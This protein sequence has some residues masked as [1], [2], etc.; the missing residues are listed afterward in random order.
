[1]ISYLVDG[2]LQV[3][4]LA[5][6]LLARPSGVKKIKNQL[7]HL[8]ILYLIYLLHARALSPSFVTRRRV[9]LGRVSDCFVH[10][11]IH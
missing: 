2:R 1:M 10:L 3:L 4:A 5:V 9:R 6:E 7:I 8:S 11:Y